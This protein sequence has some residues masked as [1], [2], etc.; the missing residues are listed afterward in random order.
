MAA[1]RAASPG[2]TA[3]RAPAA[4]AGR[5]SRAAL[6]PAGPRSRRR[7]QPAQLAVG[8]RF[9]RWGV[10]A[11]RLPQKTPPFRSGR[12]GAGQ[13]CSCRDLVRLL[14][15]L[16]VL[17][18]Q[19]PARPGVFH[20]SA[21]HTLGSSSRQARGRGEQGRVL[22]ISQLLWGWGRRAPGARGQ[23]ALAR[24]PLPLGG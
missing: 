9:W 16:R 4:P 20:L 23:L 14:S 18:P 10:R 19:F 1:G 11:A 21:P 5:G 3:A 24:H 8:R 22:R 15:H 7:F 13:T 6:T 17:D 12:R 2:Q